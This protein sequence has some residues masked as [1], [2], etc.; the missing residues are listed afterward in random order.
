MNDAIDMSTQVLSVLKPYF[1]SMMKYSAK[2]IK[3]KYQSNRYTML[4][5]RRV[6]F[7]WGQFPKFSH[8]LHAWVYLSTWQV[9]NS[10][11]NQVQIFRIILVMLFCCLSTDIW[12]GSL[13]KD[14]KFKRIFFLSS[15][16]HLFKKKIIHVIRQDMW[17]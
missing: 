10:S 13:I 6:S 2:T 1:E 5:S 8:R 4:V 16:T 17:I 9:K 7:F 15:H 3:K 14:N 12:V 11:Q